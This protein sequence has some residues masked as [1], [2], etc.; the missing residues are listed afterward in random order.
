MHAIRSLPWRSAAR[1]RPKPAMSVS[2]VVII[3][4]S[5]MDWFFSRAA[6]LSS[7]ITP[8]QPSSSSARCSRSCSGERL[9][10]RPSSG[11]IAAELK[12][13]R[14]ANFFQ[15]AGL[16]ALALPSVFEGL[17]FTR[18]QHS[19]DRK[20][21]RNTKQIPTNIVSR[22]VPSRAAVHGT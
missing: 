6:S 12:G 14:L 5:G 9:T 20:S 11:L 15:I 7:S 18:A 13:G 22:I 17:A 19:F 2:L 21:F 4:G 16:V 1:Q 10:W 8:V 3:I